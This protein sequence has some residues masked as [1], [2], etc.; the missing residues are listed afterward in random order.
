MDIQRGK[1]V[2]GGR[3]QLPVEVRRALGLED[4]DTVVMVVK[5]GELR[6]RPFRDVLSAIHKE[7]RDTI[8]KGVSLADELIAERRA[9]A[10]GE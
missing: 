4:G 2:S 1:L 8:P 3:L 5:D 6:V 7:M 10:A 9:E